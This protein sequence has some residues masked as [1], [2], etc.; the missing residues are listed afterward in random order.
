VG[1]RNSRQLAIAAAVVAILIL[2]VGAAQTAAGQS[3][4]RGAGLM[5]HADRYTELAF[6][7][8]EQLPQRL[9]AGR[10][11]LRL[12]FTL[13]NAEGAARDYRWTA[14]ARTGSGTT[15][16]AHDQTRLADG[17]RTIVRPR[18]AVNCSGSRTRVEIR[19]AGRSEAIGM[20]ASCV[21]GP[22]GG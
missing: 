16:L 14:V 1:G 5:G 3:I 6:E 22:A 19:L 7:H 20:W 18:F 11:F 9:P 13:H 12:P 10:S 21:G 2:A 8:P 17:A 4:L 15:E